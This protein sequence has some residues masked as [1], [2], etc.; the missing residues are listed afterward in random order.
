MEK[1]GDVKK[2][3]KDKKDVKADK[4]EDKKVAKFELVNEYASILLVNMLRNGD[5]IT[6]V[7]ESTKL[8]QIFKLEGFDE[9]KDWLKPLEKISSSCDDFK[10]VVLLLKEACSKDSSVITNLP[11]VCTALKIL[12]SK[13][14]AS[15]FY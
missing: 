9:L 4:I 14:V 6:A 12:K 7:L 3:M 13:V 1:T 15:K 11:T 8:R 5:N 2:E 10:E